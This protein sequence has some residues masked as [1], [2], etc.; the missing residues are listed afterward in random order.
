MYFKFIIG[1]GVFIM[2]TKIEKVKAVIEKFS[3]LKRK[4]ES[5]HLSKMSKCEEK[6]IKA[7]MK[8]G[9]NPSYTCDECGEI[10][11]DTESFLETANE[12]TVADPSLFVE[13]RLYRIIIC[14]ECGKV[15]YFKFTGVTEGVTDKLGV[16]DEVVRVKYN[17]KNFKGTG[18][19]MPVYF[20]NKMT[21]EN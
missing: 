11:V 3:T 10:F 6:K 15:N 12:G 1:R 4:L 19:H 16:D 5:K 14:P 13:P 7:L 18:I 2:N 17:A 20:K 9:V 21:T 8:L